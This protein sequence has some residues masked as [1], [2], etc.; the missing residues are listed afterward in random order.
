MLASVGL[1]S[2]Q[3][4]L[5]LISAG[6]LYLGLGL[7]LALAMPERGFRPTPR[8]ERASW[9]GAFGTLGASVRAVRGSSLLLALLAVNLFAGAAE[10]GLR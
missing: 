6:A 3:L 7:F 2:V 10:R 4:N 5:P 8:D 9:R 1:A